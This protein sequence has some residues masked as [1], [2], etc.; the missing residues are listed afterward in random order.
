MSKNHK[1]KSNGKLEVTENPNYVAPEET[2]YDI[3]R[4]WP[5]YPVFPD[6]GDVP[7]PPIQFEEMTPDSVRAG[8]TFTDPNMMG[9]VDEYFYHGDHLS[10]V[11]LV[12]DRRAGIVQQFAYMPYGELLVEDSSVDLDYRFSAKET[13]RE[14]GLSYFGA[15]YYD[16]IVAVWMGT[17]PVFH[18]GSNAYAYCLGNPINLVDPNGM[19]EYGVNKEGKVAWIRDTNDEKDLLI[20]GVSIDKNGQVERDKDGNVKGLVYDKDGKLKNKTIEVSKGV[21]TRRST[22]R[23]IYGGGHRY[24]FKDEEEAKKVFEFMAAHTNVEWS[25]FNNRVKDNSQLDRFFLATSHQRYEEYVSANNM[26]DLLKAKGNIY[27]FDYH[28]HSHPIDYG[29]TLEENV[30]P[31]S[32]DLN[33]VRSIRMADENKHAIDLR[34]S[35]YCK[36][37]NCYHEYTP[38]K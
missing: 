5:K 16:P 34:F 9:E 2:N 35:I 36:R 7:G 20:S 17:D 12:T 8:Y 33:M 14:T 18:A 10:S 3:P 28:I 4:G 27:Y 6:S 25:F 22:E 26:I 31:S 24:Q 21:F 38:K 23:K 19:H 11:V 13:D 15:R 29:A 32:K 1:H 30:S 37:D